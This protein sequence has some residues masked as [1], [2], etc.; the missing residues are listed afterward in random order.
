LRNHLHVR[1]LS[2]RTPCVLFKSTSDIRSEI[3]DPTRHGGRSPTL[4]TPVD[5]LKEIEVL[6][7]EDNVIYQKVLC[8]MLQRPGME[9][10]DVVQNGQE[11]V[12]R[13]LVAVRRDLHG[14][15]DADHVRGRGV[16]DHPRMPRRPKIA[17]VSAHVST[18]IETQAIDVGSK[19]FNVKMFEEFIRSLDFC[20]L[21]SPCDT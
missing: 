12:E 9:R 16:S 15:A 19:P 13:C 17:F 14:Y 20:P 2:C 10:I 18:T 5:I 11:S 4:L 3:D 21:A 1:S 8:R 6:I 7:A